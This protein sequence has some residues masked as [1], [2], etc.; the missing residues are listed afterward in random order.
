M[1]KVRFNAEDQELIVG[2]NETFLKVYENYDSPLM[3]GC[4][5]GNCGTCK[6]RVLDNY[7]NLSPMDSIEREF[8]D[9][10]DALENERLACQCKILGDVTIDIADFGTDP[11]F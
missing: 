1:Y 9:S 7:E 11:I 10:I 8:L 6:I 4:M 2:K 5:E 3:F